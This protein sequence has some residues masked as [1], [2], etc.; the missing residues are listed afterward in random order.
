MLIDVKSDSD[1]SHYHSLGEKVDDDAMTDSCHHIEGLWRFA[2]SLS[3]FLSL[4]AFLSTEEDVDSLPYL[5]ADFF[6]SY[7]APVLYEAT[8]LQEDFFTGTDCSST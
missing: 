8:Y 5:K 3:L 2:L 4:V 1:W 7:A 6:L